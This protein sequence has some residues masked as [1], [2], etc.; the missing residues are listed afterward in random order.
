[1]SCILTDGEG[2]NAKE[3]DTLNGANVLHIADLITVASSYER[4]WVP[5]IKEHGGNIKWSL[6][7]VDRLQGGKA[8]LSGLGVESHAMIN[9]D[10]DLF[11]NALNQNLVSKEQYDMVLEFIKEP[12]E[13]MKAFIKAHPEFIENALASDE[14]TASRA[15]L[16]LEKKW[17]E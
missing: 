1:M 10:K 12:D 16:C 7:V 2:N 17:Y 6:A 9:I 15:Q 13:S 11:D 14:K 8:I 4:A 5:A 3:L